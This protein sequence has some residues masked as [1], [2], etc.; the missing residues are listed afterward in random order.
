MQYVALIHAD[1]R[2]WE[3][4]TDDERTSA[5][6][7]YM[8]LSSDARAAGVMIDGNEL[9]PTELATCVRLSDGETVITDG[10][11]AEIKEALG[12]YYIFECGSMEEAIGWAARIPAA[13]TGAVEVRAV[14]TEGGAS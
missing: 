14:H 6:S 9:G 10:P 1:E 2:A 8:Q 12:G 13:A 4:L 5:Y 11:Y 3:A 7:G